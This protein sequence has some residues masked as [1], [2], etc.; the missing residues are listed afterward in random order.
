MA[1]AATV[2]IA[3]M[4]DNIR[5]TMAVAIASQIARSTCPAERARPMKD[6]QNYVKINSNGDSNVEWEDL[7]LLLSLPSNADVNET[8]MYYVVS[9]M[10]ARRIREAHRLL[11][12]P[13][14]DYAL[15]DGN[16][17]YTVHLFHV[18]DTREKAGD[19]SVA[20][21][22]AMYVL[23]LLTDFCCEASGCPVGYA[24]MVKTLDDVTF[25]LGRAAS[26]AF[27]VMT[28]EDVGTLRDLVNE[29]VAQTTRTAVAEALAEQSGGAG[30]HRGNKRALAAT[31]REQSGGADAHRGNKRARPPYPG[32]QHRR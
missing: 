19:A 3:E 30:A 24:T 29:M 16:A 14:K 13:E 18:D 21:M 11:D 5:A 12:F 32:D 20:V 6:L 31:E 25:A 17:A 28:E 4:P 1:A 27:Y 8:N 22:H 9:V 7:L 10:D 2:N 26:N 23:M 15:L